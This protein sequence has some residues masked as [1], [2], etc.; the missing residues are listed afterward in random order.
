[1][2]AVAPPKVEKYRAIKSYDG[3]ISFSEGATLFV[4]GEPV[5]GEVMVRVQMTSRVYRDGCV[6]HVSH[7]CAFVCDV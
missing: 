1:M 4:L 7:A 5:D 2:H 6:N 3:E